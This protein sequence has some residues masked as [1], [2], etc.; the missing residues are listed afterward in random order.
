MSITRD[1]LEAKARQLVGTVEETKESAKQTS[2]VVGLVVVG[3]IAAAFFYGR[4]RARRDRTLVEV[5]K[6]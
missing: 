4:R 6:V 5:Y 3:V 2:I 1:D